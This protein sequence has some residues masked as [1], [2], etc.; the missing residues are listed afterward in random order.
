MSGLPKLKISLYW[1]ILFAFLITQASCRQDNFNPHQDS[2]IK[3]FGSNSS[4]EGVDIKTLHNGGYVVL[5]NSSGDDLP[6]GIILIVTDQYGN[7][8]GNPVRFE[9]QNNFRGHAITVLYDGGFAI[10][11]SS[12]GEENDGSQGSNILLIRTDDRGNELWSR[13][14]N[15]GSNQIGYDIAETSDGGFIIIGTS[16]HWFTRKA[17]IFLL[18]TDSLGETEWTRTHGGWENDAGF[19]IAET[20][21]GYIYTGYTES[22]SQSGQSNSNIFIVKTNDQGRGIYPFTYGGRGDDYGKMVIPHFQGGYLL[23]GTTTDNETGIKNVFLGHVEEDISS[24]LWIRHFGD[25]VSHTAARMKI[26]H[27]GDY[28][29]TGTQEISEDN[30]VIFLLKTD[31][32]G[33]KV[34]MRTFGGSGVQTASGLD[35]TPDGGYVITGLNRQEGKSVITLIKTNEHGELR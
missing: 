22:F 1:L 4:N 3:F 12:T 31:P 21:Y 27:E 20:S 6:A 34:F 9:G 29:I 17:N 13:T 26:T 19:S 28:I 14:Y 24:P 25:S 7:Q 10:T 15:Y 18:K 30:H 16:E 32:E 11:G 35:I 33:D 2:F 8:T 23:L 5:A